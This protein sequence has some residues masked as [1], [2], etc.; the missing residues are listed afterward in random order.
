MRKFYT[1]QL[2]FAMAALKKQ[3]EI[4]AQ[5]FGAETVRPLAKTR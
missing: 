3:S 1:I 4:W 2:V 5:D